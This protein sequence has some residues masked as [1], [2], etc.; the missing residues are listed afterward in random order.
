MSA[1]PELVIG[2]HRRRASRAERLT[3]SIIDSSTSILA[4][5]DHDIVRF[6][7]G[8]PAPDSIPSR[9]LAEIA[10]TELSVSSAYD[11]AETKGDP[12]LL[13]QIVALAAG[14][15]REVAA[16]RLLVTSGGMQGLDLACKLYVEPGDLVV[17][18]GPTYTNGTATIAS[19][20]GTVLEIPVDADGMVVEALVERVAAAGRAP[21]LIYTI[22]NFQNPS[23]TTLSLR[24][25][26]Q[27]MELAVKWDAVVLED[28]P[29][30]LLRFGGERM[31]SM[32]ELAD[33]PDRVVRVE[34][35]SKI[36]APG[37]R[38][39]WVE[40][41]PVTIA[42]MVNAKQAMDTCTNLPA[43][44]L[45]AAFLR[46]GQMRAHVA[47][48]RRDYRARRDAMQRSLSA[49]FAGADV[50]WTDPA[51]G[52]FL[53]LTLPAAV[54]AEELFRNALEN[55]VAFIPGAAF[56]V[57]GRFG[58][59]LRLCFATN[60]EERIDLGVRRLRATIEQVYPGALGG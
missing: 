2:P 37:L 12:E 22:P 17:A 34:T 58:N 25:R 8:S 45:V 50:S 28:D 51:G 38:V 47:R 9:L 26:E 56:S 46:G 49:A 11:Y 29:Y 10:A 42:L 30:G 43:Q 52:M 6:A 4:E 5:Y 36:L 27:L 54:D 33:R 59:A 20:E 35:F 14:D 24:R 23:G 41:D 19:Y 32:V 16:D 31:P 55:G 21:S 40:S 18:E 1:P 7:M 39:G 3:G 44:R 15:G 13:E 53:W 57:D 60:T 48:L